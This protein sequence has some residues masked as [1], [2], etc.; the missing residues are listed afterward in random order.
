MTA[1]IFIVLEGLDGCG[2]TTQAN[3]LAARIEGFGRTVV[4]TR[5]PGGTEVG[6]RIRDVLLDARTGG[7]DPRAEVFLYQAARAHLVSSVIRPALASGHVVVCERWHYAT[8]AY[9]TTPQGDLT[10]A[11]A[12][13]VRET[14][15]WAT[16]GTEPNRAVLL[17]MP[18][19]ETGERI[20][21]PLD[22]IESRGSTYREGV[23]IAFREIF[24]AD[25]ERLRTVS[26]VGSIDTVGDRVWEAV[27]D[28]F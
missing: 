6:E 20:R 14:S 27:A 9:Q 22:R 25:P 23:A 28:L 19:D 21:R 26:A 5:E 2:K 15:A 12:D 8:Q 16:A 18:S 24:D 3:R 4:H 7:M 11:P 10:G 1:G 17:D 13:M